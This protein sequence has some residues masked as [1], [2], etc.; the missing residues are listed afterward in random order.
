MVDDLTEGTLK[1]W[2]VSLLI[3][4]D[5][6]GSAYGDEHMPIDGHHRLAAAEKLGLTLDAWVV[7]GDRFETLDQLCRLDGDDMRAED[8]V[9]C[10]GVPAMKVAE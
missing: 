2:P 9:F 3:E 8:C 10:D 4:R 1:G 7:P 5:A 6:G